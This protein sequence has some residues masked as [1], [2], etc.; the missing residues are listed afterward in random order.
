MPK[1]GMA[2][3]R[4]RAF[5]E[6][7]IRSIHDRGFVDLTTGDVARE[8]G[9]SQG[10][11]HHYFGSKGA[12]IIATMRHL[13]IEFGAGIRERLRAAE[14]PRERL[15]AIVDGSFCDEQLRPEVISAWLTFYVQAHTE[16]EVR[17]LLRIYARRLISN[18]RHEYKRVPTRETAEIAA[19]S[20]AAMIDGLWLRRVLGDAEPCGESAIAIMEAHID[21]Q[22]E[23]R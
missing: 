13:L 5:V 17:R 6:A 7:A 12:L 4:R 19:E 3:V 14:T 15:S 23:P 10:L 20:T 11:V 2:P 21:S 9:L 16:P 1:T 8:A 18:L 22:L